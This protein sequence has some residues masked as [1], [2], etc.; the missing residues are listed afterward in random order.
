[1]MKNYLTFFLFFKAKTNEPT[2]MKSAIVATMSNNQSGNATESNPISSN[3]T[4]RLFTKIS[5]ITINT[6]IK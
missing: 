6:T 2:V 3:N 5:S 1:M 4:P